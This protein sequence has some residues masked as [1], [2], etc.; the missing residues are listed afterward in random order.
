MKKFIALVLVA[1]CCMILFAACRSD[2]NDK[3]GTATTVAT[4]QKTEGETTD[5]ETTS[6]STTESSTTAS[7]TTAS[8]TE[9]WSDWY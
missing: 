7:S 5:S 3:D 1:L 8:S 9:R 4:T 2:N 6:S